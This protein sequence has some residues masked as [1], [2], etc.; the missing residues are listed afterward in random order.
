MRGERDAVVIVVAVGGGEG[1]GEGE[2]EEERK[3]KQLLLG[4][5]RCGGVALKEGTRILMK[6]CSL[7]STCVSQCVCKTLC[8]IEYTVLCARCV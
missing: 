6:V 4:A 7:V 5:Q 3:T 2:E 8:I 1:E